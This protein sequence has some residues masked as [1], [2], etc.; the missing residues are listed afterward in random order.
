[1]GLA[2]YVL[3][4]IPFRIHEF[5]EWNQIGGVIKEVAD[6]WNDTVYVYTYVYTVEPYLTTTLN[7]TIKFGPDWNSILL[8]LNLFKN[9]STSL[10]Q[11]MMVNF[12]TNHF[13][14]ATY[15]PHKKQLLS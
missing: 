7:M 5:V 2:E 11:I 15:I 13:S 9:V 1:M 14:L 10:F 8:I 3:Q 6:Y 4:D 12:G